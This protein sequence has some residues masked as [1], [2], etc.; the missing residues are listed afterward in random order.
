MGPQDITGAG[1]RQFGNHR[2]DHR[3][4]HVPVTEH[5]LDGAYVV[6]LLQQVGGEGVAEGV[7]LNG[8]S[9]ADGAACRAKRWRSS[10]SSSY[11]PTHQASRRP[12]PGQ[13]D[14]QPTAS[15][16]APKSTSCARSKSSTLLGCPPGLPLLPPQHSR[17]PRRAETRRVST[18]G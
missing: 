15:K 5:L 14:R 17:L 1:R 7:G 12:V 8:V 10:G 2:V 3:R 11:S 9:S 13:E 4:A 18:S 16:G 6:V